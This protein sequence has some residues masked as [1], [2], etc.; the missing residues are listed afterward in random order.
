[1]SLHLYK[2]NYGPALLVQGAGPKVAFSYHPAQE[3]SSKDCC[4]Q[5]DRI[6]NTLHWL[7]GLELEGCS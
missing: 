5:A 6:S 3:A 4:I 7:L 1:M 2:V